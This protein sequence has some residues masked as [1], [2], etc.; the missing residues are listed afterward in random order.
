[1]KTSRSLAF[2]VLALGTSAF[3]GL[4][5]DGVLLRR[6]LKA[7]TTDTYTIESKVQ[8]TVNSPL[9]DTPM[10]INMTTTY[11]V[12]TLK[13]DDASQTADAEIT[14]TVEKID[15]DGPAAAMMGNK[16]AP[17]MQKGKLD[18]R[19]RFTPEKSA[20]AASI[21]SLLSGGGASASSGFFVEL[22]EKAVKV[23]DTW[24]IVIPKSPLTFD[25][26]QK[27]TAK[28]VG[29]KDLDGVPVWVVSVSGSL[30][31]S[32]DSSKLPKDAAQPDSPMGPITAIVKGQ[33]DLTSE[34]LVEKATGRTL[35]MT[36]RGTL[37]SNVE[38][39]EAGMTITTSGTVDSIVKLKKN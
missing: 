22:P 2:A 4:Q 20:T 12:K 23:G 36:S 14:T 8:Q 35:E 32:V 7:D 16:P 29:E 21:Q 18:V 33:I 25:Q 17:I 39:V 19:G 10:N 30:K 27:L 11:A 15:V 6:A 37:K 38:L 24:D 5:Q 13:V 9:G 28:L 1:M 31:T 26:D 34:G 3:A